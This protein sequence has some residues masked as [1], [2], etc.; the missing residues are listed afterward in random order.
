MIR[1]KAYFVVDFFGFLLR[2]VAV[3][4]VFGLWE[5]I[6]FEQILWQL[7]GSIAKASDAKNFYL[8]SL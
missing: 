7:F 4:E 5:Q 8:D 2:Q 6:C 1:S 3:H